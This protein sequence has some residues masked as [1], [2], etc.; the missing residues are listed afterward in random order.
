MGKPKL[1]P[2][3]GPTPEKA[4]YDLS[5]WAPPVKC[6]RHGRCRFD[7]YTML[8]DSRCPDHGPA[9]GSAPLSGVGWPPLTPY[10]ALCRDRVRAEVAMNTRPK[11]A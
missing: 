2:T 10:G 7:R 9:E 8:V 5:G 3:T 1:S 11:A 6:T 4:R